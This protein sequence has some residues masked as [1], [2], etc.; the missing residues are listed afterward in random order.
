MKCEWCAFRDVENLPLCKGCPNY[1]PTST[2]TPRHDLEKVDIFE[3]A[4][5]L[6][7]KEILEG[8][9]SRKG[10]IPT[11]SDCPQCKRRYLQFDPVYNRF[12]CR[13][14]ECALFGKLIRQPSKLFTQIVTNLLETE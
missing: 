13:N 1:D 10:K 12:E 4:S 7:D 2:T 9:Q 6:Y 8:W 14:K 3:V 11:L 5:K